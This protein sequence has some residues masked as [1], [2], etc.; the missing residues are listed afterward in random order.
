MKRWFVIMLS[1][2]STAAMPMQPQTIYRC[3]PGGR[4]LS[5]QPCRDAA[6]EPQPATPGAT[7]DPSRQERADA[8]NRV[9][10]EQ[11]L[12]D[13]MERERLAREK[14]D[15]RLGARAIG[16]NTRPAPPEPSRTKSPGKRPS[17]ASAASSPARRSACASAATASHTRP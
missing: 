11:A 16:I 5:Q 4:E 7:P 1:A 2:A 12:A 13:R 14:A 10:R 3:G 9:R 6:R 15:A 8:Q 17:C